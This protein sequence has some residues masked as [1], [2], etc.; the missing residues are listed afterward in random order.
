MTTSCYLMVQALASKDS[1][2][3]TMALLHSAHD[4]MSSQNFT[5][6]Y[7]L[8]LGFQR[9]FTWVFYNLQAHN[10][11]TRLQTSYPGQIRLCSAA[12]QCL[13]QEQL[14]RRMHMS[15]SFIVF[16]EEQYWRRATVAG[17]VAASAVIVVGNGDLSSLQERIIKIKCRRRR[18]YE[19]RHVQSTL[20]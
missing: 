9:F 11:Q 4:L 12:T 7:K 18:C 14:Q 5:I 8:R 19:Q 13:Q 20:W 15:A 17:V 2:T 6:N 3:H 1:I 10:V 16:P